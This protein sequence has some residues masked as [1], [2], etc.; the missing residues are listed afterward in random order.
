MFLLGLLHRPRIL[1]KN[2]NYRYLNTASVAGATYWGQKIRDQ[3]F[4]SKRMPSSHIADFSNSL[5]QKGSAASVVLGSIGSRA[6]RN[7]LVD[8]LSQDPLIYVETTIGRCLV[9]TLCRSRG[10]R[11]AALLG[12]LI[13]SHDF[14][15]VLKRLGSGKNVEEKSR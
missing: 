7:L 12:T 8:L 10:L 15:R 5:L 9:P 6:R 1:V 2:E 11:E 13:V 4:P 14:V 3:R